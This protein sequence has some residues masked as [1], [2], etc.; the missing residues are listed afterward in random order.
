[1]DSAR[2]RPQE[3]TKRLGY[4]IE[5]TEKNRRFGFGGIDKYY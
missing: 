4:F 3:F 1:M 2:S 5:M